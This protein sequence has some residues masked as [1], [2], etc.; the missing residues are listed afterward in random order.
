M[1]QFFTVAASS[2]GVVFSVTGSNGVTASPTVGNVV[3]SGVNATTSTVGVASFNSAEFTVNGAGQ[4]SLVGASAP[5]IQTINGISPN[6][7]GNFGILGTANQIAITAGVNQDTISLIGP[8]TPSTFTTNGVLFGNGTSGIG[9]TAAVNRA[10]LT[11]G[12]TGIP[13]LI[14]LTDGQLIVGSTAGSPG[15]ASI[16]AGAGIAVTLGSNSITIANT[17]G[18]F[19]WNDQTADLNPIVPE[20][21][22][23][24]DKAASRLIL[25]LPTNAVQGDSYMISGFGAQGWQ[26]VAGAGQVIHLGNQVTSTNGTL[27]STNQWDGVELVC[28][29]VTSIFVVIHSIGSITVA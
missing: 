3:V 25:T 27:T 2:S 28:S 11:T 5:A 12:S 13:A 23:F 7:S 1:S 29:P 22:Y 4:V 24:A 14:A 26:L 8:Y 9:V 19:K 17:A 16:T 15:A 6:G 18:G 10:V 21:G 20:N